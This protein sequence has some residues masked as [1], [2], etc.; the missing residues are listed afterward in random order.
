L[1][2]SAGIGP[3]GWD[4]MFD[5]HT[6]ALDSAHVFLVSAQA[7]AAQSSFILEVG[8]GRGAQVASQPH[9]AW[10]DL[11]GPGRRVVGIDVDEAAREN[12]TIDEFHLVGDDQ[13]WPVADAA[14]DLAVSDWVLEH[15]QDP[16][17]VVAAVTRVL[18]P[19]G[20][21]LARTVSRHSPLS[22]GARLVPNRAH[23]RVLNVLQPRRLEK[24][25]FATAYRMN[26]RPALHALLDRDFEWAAASRTGLDQYLKPWPKLGR[27]V[28]GAERRLPRAA[29]MALVVCAR[30]RVAEPSVPPPA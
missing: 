17:S 2:T 15:V 27:F 8:C 6:L 21:F 19:G 25:V 5:D 1:V 24:D 16:A 9:G 10:Q 26:T 20:V 18:R 29:Q 28:E 30:R 7:L 12:P 23:P 13:R 3:L 4:Q 22:M 14:V 11:R